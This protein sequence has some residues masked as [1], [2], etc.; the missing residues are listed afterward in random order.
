MTPE[1]RGAAE[2]RLARYT[3]AME[4]VEQAESLLQNGKKWT[5]GRMETHDGC[6][7][8]VGAL[9]HIPPHLRDTPHAI[10]LDI[11]EQRESVITAC[12]AMIPETMIFRRSNSIAWITY[13]NDLRGTTWSDI[14]EALS[15]AKSTLSSTISQLK[16][17][18]S[19]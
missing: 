19:A 14:A 18:L 11:P 12:R 4:F 10:A 3:R 5:K 9:A 2:E 13:L 7:C 8:L 6:F 16:E 17:I 15:R 1:D